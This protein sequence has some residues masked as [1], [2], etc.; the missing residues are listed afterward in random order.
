MVVVVLVVE[1]V[2][3]VVVVPVVE[4]VVM[5]VVVLVVEEEEEVVVVEGGLG[6]GDGTQALRCEQR[7]PAR[8]SLLCLLLLKQGLTMW[9]WLAQN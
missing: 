2:V 1:E 8:N 9:C 3:M 6:S 5:L 4:E 7:T